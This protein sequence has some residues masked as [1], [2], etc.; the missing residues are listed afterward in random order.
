MNFEIQTDPDEREPRKL[1]PPPDYSD[2]GVKA[3]LLVLVGA[4]MLV[5]VLMN[6]ARKPENWR[7]MGFD[8]QGKQVQ[9]ESDSFTYEEVEHV[10]RE[11]LT[12]SSKPQNSEAVDRSTEL[13]SETK[14]SNKS[15]PNDRDTSQIE[16]PD[17]W[18]LVYR[19]LE[20]NQRRSLFAHLRSLRYEANTT[21]SPECGKLVEKLDSFAQQR[22]GKLL[23]ELS[24]IDED[25]PLKADLTDQHNRFQR[26]WNDE[27]K[28]AL[29][30]EISFE[31]RNGSADFGKLQAFQAVLDEAA[32]EN[33]LDNTP[34]TRAADDPAWLRTW[35][36]ILQQSAAPSSNS[37]SNPNIDFENVAPIQLRA[38]PETYRNQVVSMKGELRGIEVITTR[39][40]P[41]GIERFYSLWIRPEKS[42]IQPYNVYVTELPE[43]IE[44][45]NK[46][47]TSFTG[48][49]LSVVG[50]FFKVRSYEDASEEN[51][52]SE[53]P[54]VLAKTVSVQSVAPVV[55]IAVPW[56]PSRSMLIAFLVGM[57]LL[58]GFIAFWVYRNTTSRPHVPGKVTQ[59]KIENSL[60]GLTRDP[61]V[62]TVQEKLQMMEQDSSP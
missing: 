43:S 26:Q 2:R 57:P 33:V 62:Q 15:T 48:I 52:I 4:F 42:A 40:N 8:E 44:L 61:T 27:L 31:E 1:A 50:T 39:N 54:L 21:I 46:R 32:F 19:Q 16:Q 51:A 53:T 58:A 56:K 9:P 11:S 18:K 17:F 37:N 41:L 25:D 59:T 45:S 24:L 36:R 28:R 30:G 12:N 10:P 20:L 7:W 35:E 5:I 22:C 60:D 14:D 3:R 38:L 55:A 47:F 49:Q 34:M 6:E 23:S 29:V 13:D